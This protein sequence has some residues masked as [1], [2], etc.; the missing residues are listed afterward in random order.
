MVSRAENRGDRSIVCALRIN[1]IKSQNRALREIG[2]ACRRIL[3]P[4]VG[5]FAI[6]RVVKI[7]RDLLCLAPGVRAVAKWLFLWTIGFT[8]FFRAD[9]NPSNT[10][11]RT[12]QNK[13]FGRTIVASPDNR[14]VYY[15]NSWGI[16]SVIDAQTNR[17][18]QSQ[19]KTGGLSP[20]LAISPDSQTLYAA[21]GEKP[22]GAT[23]L[24]DVI[25]TASLSV[26]AQVPIESGALLGLTPDGKQLWIA[27]A[28]EIS[29]VDTGTMSAS[30]FSFSGTPFACAFTPDGTQAYLCYSTPGSTS[31]RIALMDTASGAVVNDDVAGDAIR[32][33]DSGAAGPVSLA[34]D[35]VRGE[36]EVEVVTPANTILMAINT[37]DYQAQTIYVPLGQGAV[38]CMCVTPN[39]KYLYLAVDNFPDSPLFE[40]VS[41]DPDSGKILGPRIRGVAPNAIAIRPDGKY[42]Y[43]MGSENLG[44]PYTNNVTIVDITP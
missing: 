41:T 25:S 7:R 32:S 17:R 22:Y 38:D 16:I 44:R 40:I 8:T 11:L 24:V 15:S 4:T 37:S 10:V 36:L 14:F 21:F 33:A 42:A 19:L 13:G 12:L 26:T 5:R 34:L 9:A 39:G 2:C 28:N 1:D 29:V 31:F 43:L 30:T 23:S 35:P 27:Y 6:I 20:V 3:F 18:S